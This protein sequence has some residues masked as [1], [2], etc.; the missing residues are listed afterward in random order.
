MNQCLNT[1]EARLTDL[2]HTGLDTGAGTARQ[3]SGVW[4]SSARPMGSTPVTR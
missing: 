3:A 2:L 4:R 1:M